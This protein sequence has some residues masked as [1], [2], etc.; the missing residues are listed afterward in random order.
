MQRMKVAAALK[1]GPVGEQIDV[2]GWVRTKR[3]S[4][5]GFAF[6]E[7]NDGSSMANLQVVVDQSVPGYAE[8]LK[9]LTTGSSVRVVGE[10]KTS[11]A[12]GQAV[13]V[14][15]RELTVYGSADAEK[16]QLQKKR[17]AREIL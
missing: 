12:K 6:V 13:E 4:K 7:L 2:R 17:H 16:Y 15:A 11:P 10:L 14:H 1:N 5:Q 9:H 8:F 3:E